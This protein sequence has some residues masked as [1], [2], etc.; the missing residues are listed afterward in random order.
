[1]EKVPCVE[2]EMTDGR[3]RATRSVGTHFCCNESLDI[4][5]AGYAFVFFE[6]R[7]IYLVSR[8]LQFLTIYHEGHVIDRDYDIQY[9]KQE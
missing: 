6:E 2:G 4:H 1:M 9:S 8:L 7:L 3:Q 5:H